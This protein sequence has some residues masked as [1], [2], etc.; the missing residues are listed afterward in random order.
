MTRTLP[1]LLTAAIL[2][3]LLAPALTACD[4]DDEDTTTTT[5][6]SST[7]TTDGDTSDDSSTDSSADTDDDATEVVYSAVDLGLSVRW[8]TF[9]V[10]ATKPYAFGSYF[11]WGETTVP[12]DLDYASDYC[13]LFGIDLL[14]SLEISDIAGNDSYDAATANWGSQWR[15]PTYDE[16][17]DLRDECSWQWTDDYLGSGIP[18][19]I[20]AGNDTSIFLPAAGYYFADMSDEC[21]ND[22]IVGCY[23]SATPNADDAT[24]AYYLSFGSS[25]PSL[26]GNNY[27]YLGQSVRPVCDAE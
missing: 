16:W 5:S 10:G 1:T 21:L 3:M 15:T 8:A 20:V 26:S 11:Q 24:Y 25:T 27:R 12:D 13:R 6:T 23:W 7:T 18:G 22:S 9:N 19:Q 2:S 4:D 14:D 17:I